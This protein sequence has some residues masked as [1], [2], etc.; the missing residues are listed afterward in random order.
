MPSHPAVIARSNSWTSLEVDAEQP[1]AVG[2]R[3]RAAPSRLDAE[4][5]V[6]QCDDEVVV[7]VTAARTAHDERHDRQALRIEVAQHLD[8]RVRVPCGD[9][10]AEHVLLVRPDHVD[11]DRILELE[12]QP[13]PDGLDDGRG[14]AL[15]TMHGIGEI[16]VL[17]RV[18]VR[19]GPAAHH[20]RDGV[21]QQLA[22]GDEHTRCAGAADELV[23]REEDGVLVGTGVYVAPR[24]ELD[25]HVGAGG[26]EV[27]EGEGAVLVQQDGDA[28]RIRDDPRDV[29]RGAEAADQQRT[30]RVRHELRLETLLVDVPVGVLGDH[31]DVG[32]GLAPRD[33]VAVVLEGADEHD[34]PPVLRDLSGR[35][36]SGHR[37]PPAPGG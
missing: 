4:D 14:A 35:A 23:R 19:H 27:P 26:G 2:T 15:L 18:D 34:G 28:V 37:G 31:H 24:R 25:V 16:D 7:Q 36:A 8:G 12:H 30:V 17:G 1:V 6:E 11:A 22:S 20:V 5:V 29:A 21:G 9:G 3:A 32:D 13:G 10:A 33:L